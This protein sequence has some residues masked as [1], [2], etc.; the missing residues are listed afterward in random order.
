MGKW[1]NARNG[2]GVF[3]HWLIHG[4]KP[5]FVPTIA[6]C[7]ASNNTVSLKLLPNYSFLLKKRVHLLV[8]LPC[9]LYACFLVR[10]NLSDR[11]FASDGS[12]YFIRFTEEQFHATIVF[13]K[14]IIQHE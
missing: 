2:V 8:A 4:G 5:V 10:E 7:N 12:K 13:E 11:K 3:E 14:L 9:E 1:F 6:I